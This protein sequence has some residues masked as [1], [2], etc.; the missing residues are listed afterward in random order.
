MNEITHLSFSRLKALSHSPL[1]LKRYIDQTRSSTKAMDEGTL[2]DCLLFEE[3][4]FK[5]R[6]FIMPEGVKK[7]TIAQ[8]NAKKPAPETLEQIKKWESIQVQIGNKIVI[9]QDQYDDSNI[10]AESVR[11][12]STV[13]F[14]GLLH[15]DNFQFQVTTDFFYKGFK[16]KGIKDAEGLDRN[17]KHVIW[18]L[19]RMGARSGEQLVRSQIRHNQYDLQA[20]IYCHKYDIE[21]IAVDYFIIAV[22]NEGYVTP[23]KISRDA[24]DKARWQWHRLIA[25]AHRVNMEG[26]DMGPEFWGDSEGFFDF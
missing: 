26:M 3:D 21:N 9:T 5:D 18:D 6:F 24:R 15:P 22:D 23:F 12:N 4:T 7:P 17:G 8:I 13:V 25:A 2:L 20:A 10:I 11:N 14:Q 19:K 1:C 16:H